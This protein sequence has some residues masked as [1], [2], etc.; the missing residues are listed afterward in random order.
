MATVPGRILPD[1]EQPV[2]PA[3]ALAMIAVVLG[4]GGL[5]AQLATIVVPLTSLGTPELTVSMILSGLLLAGGLISLGLGLAQLVLSILVV[6]RGR[7]LLR[8]GGIV[9]IVAW[10]LGVTVSFTSSGDPASMSDGVAL[11]MRVFT[12]LGIVVGV[13]R[14]LLMLVG[15]AILAYGIS[16]VRRRRQGLP[17]R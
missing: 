6:V 16:A 7:G 8:R 9:L 14:S 15:A 4:V 12:I 17:T 13:L 2:T 11:M 1:H 10:A 5:L 3:I